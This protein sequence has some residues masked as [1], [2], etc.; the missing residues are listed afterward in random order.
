MMYE[1]AVERLAL[2]MGLPPHDYLERVREA[3][4]LTPRGATRYEAIRLAAD[5]YRAQALELGLA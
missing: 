1:E 5:L 4:C 3:D 2:K